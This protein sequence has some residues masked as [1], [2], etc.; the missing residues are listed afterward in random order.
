MGDLPRLR[1]TSKEEEE[2]IPFR[3]LGESLGCFPLVNS[4]FF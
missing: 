4:Y 3:K 2:L 1:S